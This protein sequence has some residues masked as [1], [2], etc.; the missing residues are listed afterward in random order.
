M[1]PRIIIDADNIFEVAERAYTI[2]TRA[3]QDFQ[4]EFNGYILEIA[5]KSSRDDIIKQYFGMLEKLAA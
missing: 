5:K 4:I 2:C 1:K 3:K